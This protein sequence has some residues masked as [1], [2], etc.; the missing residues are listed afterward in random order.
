MK[1]Q[2]QNYIKKKKQNQI[3]KTGGTVKAG[4]EGRGSESLLGMEFQFRKKKESW[5]WM[6][7]MGAPQC[8]RAVTALES[9]HLKVVAGKFFVYFNKVN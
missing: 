6:G 3:M 7:G 9:R 2:P 5:Q 8:E 4:G 1:Y